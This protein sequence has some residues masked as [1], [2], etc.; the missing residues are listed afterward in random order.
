MSDKIKSHHLGPKA[1]LYVRQ[2]SS[3]QVIH[4]QESRLLQYA[5]RDRLC[6]LGW[7]EIEVVDD[8]LGRS[9]AGSTITMR[10]V[11]DRELAERAQTGNVAH[12]EDIRA[13]L[14]IPHGVLPPLVTEVEGI[15]AAAG[16]QEVIAGT[17]VDSIVAGPELDQ[18]V[19]LRPYDGVV[20][21]AA[22]WVD[23]IPVIQGQA[24]DRDAVGKR[25][26]GPA[27]VMLIYRIPSSRVRF[28]SNALIA[29]SAELPDIASAATSGLITSG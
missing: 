1:I 20:G 27:I 17:A 18:I 14:E 11:A 19:E 25:G 3:H 22:R 28:R 12:V 9:A 5:M 26:V 8:D 4:N 21:G 23:Q 13:D 16:N 24:I 7:R 29:T 6:A 15:G 2:S 10:R